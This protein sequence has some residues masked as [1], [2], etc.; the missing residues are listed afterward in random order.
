M[1]TILLPLV[2]ITLEETLIRNGLCSTTQPFE[3]KR[4]IACPLLKHAEGI[5][6]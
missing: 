4:L 1:T 3:R 2:A 5:C 6:E